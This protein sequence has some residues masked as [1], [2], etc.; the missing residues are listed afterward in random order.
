[1]SATLKTIPLMEGSWGSAAD[2]AFVG[3]AIGMEWRTRGRL[4]VPGAPC[5][6]AVGTP[7]A[8]GLR[9]VLGEGPWF[10]C[11][12]TASEGRQV[13]PRNLRG[14]EKSQ[15]QRR[16]LR[17][18]GAAGG[19]ENQEETRPRGSGRGRG[20][21]PAAPGPAGGAAPLAGIQLRGLPAAAGWRCPGPSAAIE[22]EM[23]RGW[24]MET[25]LPA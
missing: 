18:P 19:T 16:G 11:E 10:R 1:M 12:G 4:A 22:M 25:S 24:G 20:G 9:G 5:C 15:W 21:R 13:G 17:R 6:P 2:G 23:P 7:S 3:S 8:P 14:D